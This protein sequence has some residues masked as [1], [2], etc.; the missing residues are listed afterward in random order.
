M[1]K[2]FAG[3]AGAFL[4]LLTLAVAN[5]TADQQ[6]KA[7]ALLAADC[8]AYA[9]ALD[10]LQPLKPQMSAK[11]LGTV[12]EVIGV[13]G[14]ICKQAAD[15]GMAQV[16]FDAQAMVTLVSNGLQSLAVL[17]SEVPK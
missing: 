10:S 16:P 9:S 2:I 5:C 14:P 7:E 17:Q 1:Q 3:F 15:L 4:L 8:V 11:Q 13:V 12:R 6:V